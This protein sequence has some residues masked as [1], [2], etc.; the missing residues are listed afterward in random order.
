MTH[1]QTLVSH[2]I[3]IKRNFREKNPFN[4]MY[5]IMVC[6]LNVILGGKNPFNYTYYI[7]I[8]ECSNVSHGKYVY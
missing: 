6:L 8:H 7:V 5:Y 2:G 4:Y 1:I 3:F